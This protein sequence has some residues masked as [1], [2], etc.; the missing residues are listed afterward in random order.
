MIKA[1]AIGT[2]Q[3][4]ATIL[5]GGGELCPYYYMTVKGQGVEKIISL[6]VLETDNRKQLLE[7]DEAQKQGLKSGGYTYRIYGEQEEKQINE[8]T[9]LVEF[10]FFLFIDDRPNKEIYQ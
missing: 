6:T 5:D 2:T 3:F 1:T 9:N 10:G 4:T 8:L 7:F